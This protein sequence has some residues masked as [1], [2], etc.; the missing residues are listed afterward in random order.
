MSRFDE[1]VRVLL[2]NSTD[3]L[4][5]QISAELAALDLAA[6]VLCINESKIPGATNCPNP[7]PDCGLNIVQKTA[8]ADNINV[9]LLVGYTTG[10]QSAALII[11]RFKE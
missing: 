6:A 10:G 3:N 8:S 7:C 5:S 9:V 4:N 11:K 2:D 1:S